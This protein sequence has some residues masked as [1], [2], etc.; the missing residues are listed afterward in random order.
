MPVPNYILAYQ[1]ASQRSQTM[2]GHFYSLME[3]RVMSTIH[4][5]YSDEKATDEKTSQSLY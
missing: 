1:G 3:L 2:L 4:I 5:D